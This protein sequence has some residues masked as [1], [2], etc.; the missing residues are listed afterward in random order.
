MTTLPLDAFPPDNAP[1]D[2]A[3]PDGVRPGFIHPA[4]I[5]RDDV[6]TLLAAGVLAYIAETLLHE[7]AGH[8]GACLAQAHRF[9]VLAPLWMRCSQTS[10]FQV[11]AGPGMNVLAAAGFFA[12]LRLWRSVGPAAGLLLWLGFA[13]NALVACG[14]LGVGAATGFGDWPVIFGALA[15]AFWRV[16]AMMVAVLGYYLCLRVAA[17][18]YVGLAGGG[19]AAARALRRRALLPAAGAAIVACAAEIVGGRI[20]LMPLLLAFGCTAVVGY[21]LTSMD[22]VVARSRKESANG[23][24]I[25]RSVSMIAIGVFVAAAFVLVVGPGVALTAR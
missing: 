1:R 18:L 4:S 13:F 12:V 15:P 23:F 6:P 7:A 14:Y 22:D 5:R 25:R 11:A 20:S 17:F 16:P 21:S 2:S 19:A 10:L 8:G 3:T 24:V 9:L